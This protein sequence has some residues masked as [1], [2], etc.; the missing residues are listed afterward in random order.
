MELKLFVALEKYD[1]AQFLSFF[2][3]KVNFSFQKKAFYYIS[4]DE[5]RWADSEYHLGFSQKRIFTRKTNDSGTKAPVFQRLI[6]LAV[7][8]RAQWRYGQRCTRHGR[9]I[10]ESLRSIRCK[11]FWGFTKYGKACFRNLV[12]PRN[13][14]CFSRNTYNFIWFDAARRSE[15][16]YHLGFSFKIPYNPK[17]NDSRAETRIFRKPLSLFLF[18]GTT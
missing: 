14:L 4:S 7:F 13:H 17:S 11:V 5:T 15:S 2:F 16:E 8:I 12:G 6:A 9:I 3:I 10:S 18:S 1:M